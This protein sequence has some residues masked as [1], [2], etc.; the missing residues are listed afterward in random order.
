MDR[1]KPFFGGRRELMPFL[2]VPNY[3]HATA[4]GAPRALHGAQA[5]RAPQV[6]AELGCDS[7]SGSS[8]AGSEVAALGDSWARP[9]LEPPLDQGSRAEPTAL[10]L[11]TARDQAGSSPLLACSRASFPHRA[12]SG[13]GSSF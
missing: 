9:S 8:G 10:Q 4:L 7:P 11:S 3:K 5:M 6:P 1:V 13:D 12:H 2:R